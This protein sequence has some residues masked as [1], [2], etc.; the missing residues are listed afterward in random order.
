MDLCCSP[1]KARSRAGTDGDSPSS[2]WTV[3]ADAR[4]AARDA[5]AALELP[6]PG[7]QQPPHAPGSPASGALEVRFSHST[8]GAETDSDSWE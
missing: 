1:V 8:T 3:D 2:R 4:R 5:T 6:E 7:G